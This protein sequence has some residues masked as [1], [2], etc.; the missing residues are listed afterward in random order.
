[1][2]PPEDAERDIFDRRLIGIRRA[3]A[4]RRASR[5]FLLERVA[6]D[7]VERICD[8]NRQFDQCL[9]TGLPMVREMVVSGL[10]DNKRPARIDEIS[11]TGDPEAPLKHYDLVVSLLSLHAVNSM[12]ETLTHIRKILKPDGHFIGALFGGE[13]LNELRRAC[14]ALDNIRLGGV[15]P[16]VYP[17]ANHLQM[18]PL[19]QNAGFALP[20][21]DRDRVSVSYAGMK[22]L[23][24]DLR[25]LG[26]TNSLA[27]RDRR[28]LGRNYLAGFEALASE[29][30][31]GTTFDIFWMTGWAPHESQQKPL[32]PGSAQ[33]SLAR[34]F[35]ANS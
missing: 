22:T 4:E 8:I 7:A 14:Y 5:S 9:I 33:V 27:M 1:M 30:K 29:D 6:D 10:P 25:D 20:V 35:K 24:N 28:Y 31:F 11:N 3:R 16:R 32:E 19:L 23:V 26:E 13:T 15:T 17:F 18:A 34:I 2:N 21:I 12:F